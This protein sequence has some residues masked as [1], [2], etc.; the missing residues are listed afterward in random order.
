MFINHHFLPLNGQM[1]KNKPRNQTSNKFIKN[2]LQCFL[3]S[4]CDGDYS[5]MCNWYH[6]WDR[7]SSTSICSIAFESLGWIFWS[8]ESNCFWI[9]LIFQKRT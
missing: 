6:K 4:G 1:V 8:L 2:H 9:Q 5:K 3:S 7:K